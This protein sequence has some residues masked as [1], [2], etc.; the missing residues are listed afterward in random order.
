MPGFYFNREI[1]NKFYKNPFFTNKFS[2]YLEPLEGNYQVYG[3]VDRNIIELYFNNGSSTMTNTFFMS[4]GNLPNS[5]K[6]LTSIDDVFKVE[7]ANI[8]ILSL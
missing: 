8:R 2:T 5:I 3:I 6:I 7:E 4:E 1:Q